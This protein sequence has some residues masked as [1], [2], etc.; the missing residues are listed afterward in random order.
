MPELPE[1][2][3]IRKS[4]VAKLKGTMLNEVTN[5][6]ILVFKECEEN[7]IKFLIGKTLK[8]I[9]RKGKY[10]YFCFENTN[11]CL[12]SHLGMTG[13]YLFELSDKDIPYLQTTLKFSTGI[14]LYYIDVRELGSFKISNNLKESFKNLGIEPLSNKLTLEYLKPF[15]KSKLSLKSWLLQQKVIA[16]L[17]NI[18]SDEALFLA[19]LHPLRKVNSLSDKEVWGLI[20]AIKKTIK[21]ALAFEGTVKAYYENVLFLS[22]NNIPAL[23]VYGRKGEPCLVCKS[24]I[25][26]LMYKDRGLHYCINCQV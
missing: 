23:N 3:I 22:G 1:V 10:M 7:K 9:K 21:K 2:E 24:E 19:N 12:I 16:G 13:K 15:L 18:Y 26:K 25:I 4:L 17:G 11:Y 5:T 14:T 20:K 6:S 8:T